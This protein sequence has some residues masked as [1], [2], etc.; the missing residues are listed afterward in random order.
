MPS[1]RRVRAKSTSIAT[2]SSPPVGSATDPLEVALDQLE[3]VTVLD[4]GA[5]GVWHGIV[6]E[7]VGADDAEGVDPVDG[8]G[9]PGRLGELHRAEPVDRGDHGLGEGLRDAR[10]PHQND[11]DLT[12]GARE[13]DPVVEAAPLQR[14]VQLAGAVGG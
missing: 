14:V 6:V 7:V 10:R 13:A 1:S 12:L 3:V 8:L 5:E 2:Y 4:D 11:L 9:D